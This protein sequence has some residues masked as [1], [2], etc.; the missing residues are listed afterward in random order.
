ML[1]NFEVTL[2]CFQIEEMVKMMVLKGTTDNSKI[3]AAVDA[4][5]APS[6]EWEMEMYSEAIIYAKQ[7]LLN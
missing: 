7:S 2:N 4:Q 3:V 6:S 5:F 1:T